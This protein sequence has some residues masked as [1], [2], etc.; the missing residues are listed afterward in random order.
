MAVSR[1]L[2]L[3]RKLMKDP[4]LYDQYQKLHAW[5]DSRIVLSWLTSEQTEFKIFV[6]N[7]LAKIAELTPS[8]NWHYISSEL[9]PSDCVSHGLFPSE[10]ITNKLYWNG[11]PFLTLPECEWPV[12]FFEPIL[13]SLLP[14]VKEMGP[15][16]LT[17]LDATSHVNDKEWVAR[18]SSVT[19]LQRVM[20]YVYRFIHRTRKIVLLPI[21]KS[22]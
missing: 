11:P 16:T 22:P 21:D 18:F 15:K 12:I 20:A 9:N 17:N 5:T 10:A 13:S 19:R 2:N 7:R 14:E 8:C 4:V 1:F 6:T 3:E